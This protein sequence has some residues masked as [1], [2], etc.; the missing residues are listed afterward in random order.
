MYQIKGCQIKNYIKKFIGQ[1]K[2]CKCTVQLK[3]GME[4]SV[5]EFVNPLME[6]KSGW[7]RNIQ[8]TLSKLNINKRNAQNE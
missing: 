8:K 2:C 4:T 6:K 1:R 5:K 3:L 7:K